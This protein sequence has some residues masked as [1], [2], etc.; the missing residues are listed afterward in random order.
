LIVRRPFVLAVTLV[1][2]CALFAPPAHAS[3]SRTLPETIELTSAAT[4]GTGFQA[5]GIVA[6]GTHAWA[7]SLATG[8]I[9]RADL[10]TG[11]VATVVESAGG[12][13][14]GLAL[15]DR[16]RLWVAG[17]PA[18]TGRVYDAQSGE[19]LA[20]L[21][22]A[23]GE[24]AFVNDVIVAHDAAWFTD[25]FNAVLYR[26]PLGRKGRIGTPQAVTLGGDFEL[27]TGPDA[28]NGNGIVATRDGKLIFA[29]S[30]DPV[31]GQGSALYVADPERGATD[32]AAERIELDG[33]VAN[34]DG[35]VLHGRTLYVVENQL[36][37]I[38]KVR[39]S[40]DSA[41][42]R[43]TDRITDDDFATPTTASLA[44]GAL[45]AVNA[46]FADI[47]GGADPATLTY[48]IVR[49]R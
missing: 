30:A 40:R 37:R 45:Y 11:D 44:L 46:R 18:G 9:V 23:D 20:D 31:D 19:L 22:L 16:H 3:R 1:A 33:D 5:E 26:V 47:G 35:L 41:S 32:V 13:A 14:V 36:N 7:G 2:A 24:G 25:S 29:Q 12:P 27:V 8:T 28:F 6:R 34:A 49:A 38:A 4:A 15:D 39:L 43:V 10:V 17:G 48:E 21:Q 42:G